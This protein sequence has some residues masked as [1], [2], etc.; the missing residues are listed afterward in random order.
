[1]DKI[2]AQVPSSI[3]VATPVATPVYT[4]DSTAPVAVPW[5]GPSRGYAGLPVSVKGQ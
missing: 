4:T 3:A 2:I 5:T 1:M